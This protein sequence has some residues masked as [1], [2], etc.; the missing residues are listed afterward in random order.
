LS[1]RDSLLRLRDGT[2]LRA[3]RTYVDD[4]RAALATRCGAGD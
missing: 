4:L 1:N 3:S 2:P